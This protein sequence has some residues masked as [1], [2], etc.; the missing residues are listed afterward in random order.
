M[1]FDYDKCKYLVGDKVYIRTKQKS[2]GSVSY[3]SYDPEMENFEAEVHYIADIYPSEQE[4]KFGYIYELEYPVD[5]EEADEE[6]AADYRWRED[7]LA[8]YDKKKYKQT[9][10]ELDWS[11]FLMRIGYKEKK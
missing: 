11:R 2:W 8:P 4:T 9:E 6:C 10:K 1:S 3:P 5:E 7:W